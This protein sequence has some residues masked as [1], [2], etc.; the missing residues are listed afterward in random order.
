MR[1]SADPADAVRAFFVKKAD[2]T[3]CG[4]EGVGDPP[5]PFRPIGQFQVFF[6][7]LRRSVSC[8]TFL[9]VYMFVVHFFWC[10]LPQ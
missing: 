6:Y 2:L 10:P 5:S 4:R 3:W 7:D 1:I 9:H 8:K